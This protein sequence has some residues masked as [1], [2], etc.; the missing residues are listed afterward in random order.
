MVLLIIYIASQ[1]NVT[2]LISLGATS[3][4]AEAN[5]K[6]S[7]L[8]DDELKHLV[9]RVIMPRVLQ[10]VQCDTYLFYCTKHQQIRAGLLT[11]IFGASY[12]IFRAVQ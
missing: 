7:F 10:W 3:S 9:L 11:F 2:F 6:P 4:F 1:Y 8:P 5:Y 12:S